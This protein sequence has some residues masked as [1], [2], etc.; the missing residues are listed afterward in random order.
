[1][2]SKAQNF[3]GRLEQVVKEHPERIEKLIATITADANNMQ[4]LETMSDE[5]IAKL[6]IE[7]VWS[8][9]DMWTWKSAIVEVAAERL[10]AKA[11]GGGS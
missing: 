5:Q 4:Q 1:M 8:D 2:E 6:L 3:R 10:Q 11:A 9:L 7:H